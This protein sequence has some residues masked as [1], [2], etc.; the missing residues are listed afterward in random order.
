MVK[1]K[2]GSDCIEKNLHWYLGKFEFTL[3][4]RILQEK[5]GDSISSSFFISLRYI[6]LGDVPPY[7]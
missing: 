3:V 2:V 4:F 1:L 6:K 7:T 5:L